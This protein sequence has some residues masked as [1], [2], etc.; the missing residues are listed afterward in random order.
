[1]LGFSIISDDFST[2][3]ESNNA[4][5]IN[6]SKLITLNFNNV[7]QPMIVPNLNSTA[8]YLIP[9]YSD[10]GNINFLSETD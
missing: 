5:K 7:P 2:I 10:Q 4:V 3:Y 8:S 9:I 1:M 6:S